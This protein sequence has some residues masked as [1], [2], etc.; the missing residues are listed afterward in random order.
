MPRLRSQTGFT[1]ILP[2]ELVERCLEFLPF[3]EVHTNA[4]QVSKAMRSAARRCL[5]RGRWRPLKYVVENAMV[6]NALERPSSAAETATFR[7]AWAVD[8][9]QVLLEFILLWNNKRESCL[10]GDSTILTDTFWN[11]DRGNT[12]AG[13]VGVFKPSV[14]RFLALVEPSMDG[15]GRLTMALESVEHHLETRGRGRYRAEMPITLLRLWMERL[16]E[17]ALLGDYHREITLDELLNPES[18]V[19]SGLESWAE[20]SDMASFIFWLREW[21]SDE[22]HR[23]SDIALALSMNW[24]DRQKAGAFVAAAVFFVA[25]LTS[26]LDEVS[27]A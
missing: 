4:K 12:L 7:A 27:A 15:L 20:P 23:L 25:R 22:I 19:G 5:T 8:P 17:F 6:T 3:E 11:W 21:D 26:D 14:A 24:Q 10:E 16:G 1:R 13:V 18:L 2:P 9:R